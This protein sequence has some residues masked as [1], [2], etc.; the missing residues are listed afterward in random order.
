LTQNEVEAGLD[1]SPLNI[2][3][4]FYTDP[5]KEGGS[6]SPDQ[7]TVTQSMGPSV[8]S[9]YD[10]YH[11]LGPQYPKSKINTTPQAFQPTN[12]EKKEIKTT[13]SPTTKMIFST[14]KTPSYSNNPINYYDPFIF[15]NG[16]VK[17]KSFQNHS[18]Y[19]QEEQ[20]PAYQSLYTDSRIFSVD[21]QPS[22]QTKDK[23]ESN[24]FEVPLRNTLTWK[25]GYNRANSVS[26]SI[27]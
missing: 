26:Q 21:S 17:R 19:H 20:P 15:H 18:V 5:H 12:H 11:G 1:K 2:D 25:Q 13:Y 9:I 3:E 22:Y 27:L 6:K 8:A 10:G 23:P 7:P 16:K 14:T 4:K 24:V